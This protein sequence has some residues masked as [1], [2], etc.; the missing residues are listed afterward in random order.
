MLWRAAPGSGSAL[1]LSPGSSPKSIGKDPRDASVRPREWKASA[2][3]RSDRPAPC[4]LIAQSRGRPCSLAVDQAGRPMGVELQHPVANDL[5]AHATN[6]RRFA[7]RRA[8]K[9]RSKRQEPPRLR[10]ILRAF[11]RKAA[12][13]GIVI[14]SQRNRHGEHPP[15]ATHD[16]HVRCFRNP[17][18]VSVQGIWYQYLLLVVPHQSPYRFACY[19]PV[20]KHDLCVGAQMP[21]EMKRLRQL[22]EDGAKLKSILAGLTLA[23]S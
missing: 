23:A 10:A 13:V 3:S 6:P 20:L 14:R 12:Q 22:E 5:D 9:D 1:R 18:R 15:F 8:V 19:L 2:R 11:G 21:S 4:V 17:Q 7:A 16:S